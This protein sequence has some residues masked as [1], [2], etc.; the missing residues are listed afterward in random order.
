MAQGVNMGV[1][2]LLGVVVAVLAGFAASSSISLGGRRM[3]AD[4]RR[5][6]GTD[7]C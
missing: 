5:V 1:Y 6:E 4:D 7:Q 2:F 3:F